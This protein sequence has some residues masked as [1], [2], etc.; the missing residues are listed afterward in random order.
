MNKW[1]HIIGIS[2]V[3]TSAVAVMFKNLGWKVTGSDKAFFPPASE[4]L[5]ANSIEILVGFKEE[6]LYDAKGDLPDLVIYQGMKGENNPEITFAREKGLKLTTYAES[7]VEYIIHPEQS[8]VVAGTYGKTTITAAITKMLLQADKKISYMFGGVPQDMPF[9]A[10]G[11][12]VETQYSVIE[13]DEYMI[14]L[15]Q[16]TSKFFLYKAKYLV[17]NAISWE[18]LDLFKTEDE[19][20]AN[21][22]KLVKTLPVDGFIVANAN[23]KNVV[24]VVS[25]SPCKVIYYSINEKDALIEPEWLLVKDSKPLPCFMRKMTADKPL[26]IVPYERK[27]IGEFNEENLLAAAVLVSELGVKKE[28]I[29]EAIRE[30][31]GVRRRLEVRAEFKNLMIVDDLGS[32]PPKANGTIKAIREDY[33]L[34]KIVAVLEPNAGNRVN[35]ALPL[36]KGI[37]DQIEELIIPRFSRLPKSATLSRFDEQGLLAVMKEDGVNAQLIIDDD[38]LVNALIDFYRKFQDQ[39]VIILF[40]SSHSLRGMI[41]N[42]IAQVQE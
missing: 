11:K 16:P 29:Q 33:P 17:L 42:L 32:S 22:R 24:N 34:A 21:F 3:A 35:S 27:I 10:L 18:H 4:Y 5:Q 19:Y 41:E 15:D 39:Q 40:M 1:I 13:G 12:D 26:E 25:Q 37:F 31:K 8:I 30:F 20:I 6:H 2:G 23:D 28:R 14:S 38:Q 36:F 7:L 9:N